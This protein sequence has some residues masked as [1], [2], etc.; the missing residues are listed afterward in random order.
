MADSYQVFARRFR[1]Q[2]FSEVIGQDAIVTTMRNALKSERLAH[3]YLFSG[4]RGT[5]KTSLARLF[6]K[7]M[8]CSSFTEEGEPCNHCA[9]CKEI[10]EGRSLD[11]I[12]IDGASH[13]GIDDIRAIS[14]SVSY[15]PT[16][17]KYKIYLIDEVHML[18]KEA[19]NALLKTLEEPPPKVKF[20]FATTEPHKVPATIVSRCQRF[21][22]KRL[23]PQSISKKL[24]LIAEKTYL[25]V[26]DSAIE[27]IAHYAEGGLRDAESLFDQV[28]AFS[29]GSIDEAVV[30]DV[31]GLSPE[32]WFQELDHAIETIDYRTAFSLSERLFMEGKDIGYFIHDLSE[33][34]KKALSAKI[35]TLQPGQQESKALACLTVQDCIQ[36][37]D[38]IAKAYIAMKSSSSSSRIILEWVLISIIQ[39][40]LKVPLP[41]VVKKLI[42]FEKSLSSYEANQPTTSEASSTQTKTSAPHTLPMPPEEKFREPKEVEGKKKAL[43]PPVPL[44]P[45]KERQ[46]NE[47]TQYQENK[48]L[49]KDPIHANTQTS[50]LPSHRSGSQSHVTYEKKEENQNNPA[51]LQQI[52]KNS[53]KPHEAHESA[54]QEAKS[55]KAAPTPLTAYVARAT[56]LPSETEGQEKSRQESIMQFAAVELEGTLIKKSIRP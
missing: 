49:K 12:E 21:N 55:Q 30:Q 27:R 44:D 7:A 14:D 28:A 9:S 24:K 33:H 56:P 48:E 5:G 6:A 19:F 45:P 54:Q 18:T 42:D 40:R 31:L 11:V 46:K 1:P 32:E 29:E 10:T 8:N 22:L 53:F 13:R 35:G 47:T 34:Y 52:E 4:S 51:H 2:T 15:S 20:F 26:D 38:L 36:I 25:Q 23:S 39:T 16:H 43:I 50:A 3:A 17:G 37:L 41:H